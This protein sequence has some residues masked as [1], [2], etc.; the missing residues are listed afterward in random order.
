MLTLKI[1]WSSS[2]YPKSSEQVVFHYGN[3]SKFMKSKSIKVELWLEFNAKLC[4]SYKEMNNWKSFCVFHWLKPDIEQVLASG[5]KWLLQMTVTVNTVNAKLL[6]QKDYCEV[7]LHAFVNIR[8]LFDFTVLKSFA[9]VQAMWL[10][11]RF[12]LFN[13]SKESLPELEQSS[14]TCEFCH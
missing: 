7:L 13:I 2:S 12:P 6:L 4:S 9:L 10:R 5:I 14:T 8:Q 3:I 11:S 1:L